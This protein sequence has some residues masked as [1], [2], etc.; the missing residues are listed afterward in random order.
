MRSLEPASL[1]TLAMAIATI[2]RAVLSA[3]T[4]NTQTVPNARN[5]L[6][7]GT[8]RPGDDGTTEKRKKKE[9]KAKVRVT[10]TKLSC[11]LKSLNDVRE[12]VFVFTVEKETM[13][14]K[15]VFRERKKTGKRMM[16]QALV[17]LP[18]TP[19]QKTRWPSGR[20]H[21]D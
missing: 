16:H 1:I 8:T 5:G 10:I 15:T 20:L 2:D 13:S 12:N 18:A 19:S 9:T 7:I 21:S 14:P 6:I 4:T 17:P 11:P 3:Q